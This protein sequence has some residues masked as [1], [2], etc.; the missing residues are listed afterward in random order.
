MMEEYINS[1]N[2]CLGKTS[3]TFTPLTVGA[4]RAEIFLCDKKGHSCQTSF[5][6]SRRLD[7]L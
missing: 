1:Q 2:K 7:H 3:N 6:K 5:E 4:K